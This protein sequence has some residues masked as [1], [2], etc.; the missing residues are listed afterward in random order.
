MPSVVRIKE[1][2]K[3]VRSS[4][5]TIPQSLDA[6]FRSS[7]LIDVD[8]LMDFVLDSQLSVSKITP[9]EFTDIK[10]IKAM[11]L[12]RSGN[13]CI[14]I[15]GNIQCEKMYKFCYVKELVH[16]LI[17]GKGHGITTSN[18]TQLANDLLHNK[19]NLED[20]KEAVDDILGIIGAIELLLP[21]CH[22]DEFREDCFS[23]GL[24]YVSNKFCI[25]HAMVELRYK[26]D[27]WFL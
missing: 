15:D 16:V 23:N 8:D 5:A 9:F 2:I 4:Y 25:P 26:K 18:I 14:F 27:N 17:H 20:N 7:I 13:A 21:D 12:R 24:E 6:K 11:M 22:L 10:T 3:S 19:F 1:Y